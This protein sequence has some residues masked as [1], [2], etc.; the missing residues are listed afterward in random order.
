MCIH[1]ST[2]VYMCLHVII[3]VL[4]CV[5]ISLVSVIMY[6]FTPIHV[7]LLEF[8]TCIDMELSAHSMVSHHCVSPICHLF[9]LLLILLLHLV[10]CVY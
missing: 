5:N 1:V 6:S 7:L 3:C 2:C 9:A 10:L 4:I 8:R